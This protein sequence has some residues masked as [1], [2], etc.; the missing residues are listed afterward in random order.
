M[1]TF[2]P[3][4]SP[5]PRLSWRSSKLL[6]PGRLLPTSVFQPPPPAPP[7]ATASEYW[8]P[9]VVWVPPKRRSYAESR[10]S[11]SPVGTPLYDR[12]CS[13]TQEHL[14]Q[15]DMA[16]GQIRA[17]PTP[18]PSPAPGAGASN[19]Q[20]SI[21]GS[22]SLST[23]TTATPVAYPRPLPLL[24][25]RSQ[26]QLA[27]P[28]ESTSRAPSRSPSPSPRNTLPA[29]PTSGS[30][31]LPPTAPNPSHP[32]PP[33][34][35]LPPRPTITTSSSS[36]TLA[37]TAS[38]APLTATS[39]LGPVTPSSAGPVT[40]P[41]SISHSGATS[42]HGAPAEALVRSESDLIKPTNEDGIVGLVPGRNLRRAAVPVP[43]ECRT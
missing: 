18:S 38:S 8:L 36:T 25:S 29:V 37:T 28:P 41:S 9:E 7:C 17:L 21:P 4:S 20:G 43:E 14:P 10:T 26:S 5:K 27:L 19:S 3:V 1:L 2:S 35:P 15:N 24:P 34:P 30:I 13:Q 11:P 39:S 12:L 32:L 22:G 33:L 6:F 23:T 42:G 16:I 40:A 31:P